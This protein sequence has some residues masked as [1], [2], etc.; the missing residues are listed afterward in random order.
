VP[1]AKGTLPKIIRIAC[2]RMARVQLPLLLGR[3]ARRS[4][5]REAVRTVGPIM[6]ARTDV[7][8][9]RI[10]KP[11]KH[12]ARRWIGMSVDHDIAP[13]ADK[14]ESRVER[15]LGSFFDWAWLHFDEK[16]AGRRKTKRGFVRRSAQPIDH[17]PNGEYRGRAAIRVWTAEVWRWLGLGPALAEARLA[18]KLGAQRAAAAKGRP[19]APLVA[20]LAESL[21]DPTQARPPP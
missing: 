5:L 20:Q 14:G 8:T 17:Q 21:S 2:E 3:Y 7:L 4:E 12:D 1:R 16:P 6:M 13:L 10:G 9:G 19:V 18:L 11:D 15:V